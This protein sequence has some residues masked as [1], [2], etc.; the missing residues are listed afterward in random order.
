[1]GNNNGG[2]NMR[3]VVNIILILLPLI[4][5]S[6]VASAADIDWVGW[7][8]SMY[9]TELVWSYH[10]YYGPN[11]IHVYN[12]STN[13]F[14][15][16]DNSNDSDC[17]AIYGNKIIWKVNGINSSKIVIYD[18]PS[19]AR[20]YIT[21]NVSSAPS[22]YRNIIVWE[23]DGLIYMYDIATRMQSFIG[24]GSNPQVY[25]GKVVYEA[26]SKIFVYERGS[27]IRILT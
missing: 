4:A 14:T 12:F 16:I 11:N 2:G 27:Q 21:S 6:S 26:N 8:P 23:T 1:M 18:I 10:N 15:A 13:T 3:K 22:I 7:N 20:S 17:P 19:K 24:K 5:V 9:G 25:N